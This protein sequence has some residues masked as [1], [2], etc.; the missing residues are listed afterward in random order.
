MTEYREDQD[1]LKAEAKRQGLAITV[2]NYNGNAAAPLTYPSG[3]ASQYRR[4][5]PLL[6]Q[7]D[8]ALY[9]RLVAGVLW[10]QSRTFFPPPMI[11]LP[12]LRQFPHEGLSKCGNGLRLGLH[13][14]LACV[15]VRRWGITATLDQVFEAEPI[16]KHVMNDE[17]MITR[18]FIAT[19]CAPHAA[20]CSH[21]RSQHLLPSGRTSLTTSS[22]KAYPTHCM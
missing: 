1:A 4:Q 8:L 16:I 11:R 12:A 9:T 17:Y 10:R 5:A 14:E 7:M 15:R 2:T 21:S 6:P 3:P 13:E 19:A 18:A 22:C 20:P